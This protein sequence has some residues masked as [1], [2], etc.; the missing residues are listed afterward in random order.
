MKLRCKIKN[1]LE[2]SLERLK[3]SHH[4]FTSQSFT[5]PLH[6]NH[7]H[8]GLT[9]TIYT[10]NDGYD[11]PVYPHYRY[12]VKKCWQ[13]SDHILSL[14]QLIE[15]K[16]L[17]A[18]LIRSFNSLIGSRTLLA[19]P[20]QFSEVLFSVVKSKPFL[21]E[22]QSI[23]PNLVNPIPVISSSIE[24]DRIKYFTSAH[25]KT[26]QRLSR[27]NY[28][29][30]NSG[31]KIL[32]IGFTT[33]GHSL[34]AWEDIGLSVFG[35]DNSYGNKD[36]SLNALDKA[37]LIKSKLSYTS[38]LVFGDITTKTPFEDDFF[39]C[40]YSTSVLE[41]IP[42]IPAAFT[43]MYRILRPGGYLLHSYHPYHSYDGGHC[44]GICDCPWGHLLMSKDQYLNYIK[45]L[46]PSE[47]SSAK[48]WLNT[49]LFPNHTM[50][51]MQSSVLNAN[52]QILEWNQF[53]ASNF[54]ASKLTS[55]ILKRALVINPHLSIQEILSS[56][57]SFIA[58]KC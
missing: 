44:I 35:L 27:L 34:F 24:R 54:I 46:R 3:D 21:F 26:L 9:E 31:D 43:E 13:I 48:F 53:R 50:S 6:P 56:N 52:F 1:F 37:H 4:I 45:D 2:S 22:S 47:Y 39:D 8:L 16:Q 7:E 5:P 55:A 12:G 33:G 11:I 23:Y 51:F 36:Q 25:K 14:C 18:S 58:K 38:D 42:D 49:S 10:L 20:E 28:A 17:S 30:I 15:R 40:I 29:N 32:E 57:V 41:H 19:P